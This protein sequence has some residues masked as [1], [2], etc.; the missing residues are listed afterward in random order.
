MKIHSYGKYRVKFGEQHSVLEVKLTALPV[1]AIH[2][3]EHRTRRHCMMEH[4]RE[5]PKVPLQLEFH[6]QTG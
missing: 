6:R 2:C 1:G 4:G 3:E 5:Y